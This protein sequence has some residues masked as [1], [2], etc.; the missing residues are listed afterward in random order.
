MTCEDQGFS[1]TKVCCNYECQ[2]WVN[3]KIVK[4]E[5]EKNS[6][7][8]WCC[9]KCSGS[10]GTCPHPELSVSERTGNEKENT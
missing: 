1:I 5:L 9:P 2:T 3:G 7:G 4:P 6:K 8:F 10:Y